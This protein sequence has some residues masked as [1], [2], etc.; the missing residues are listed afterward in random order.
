MEV[1]IKGRAVALAAPTSHVSRQKALLAVGQDTW[2]GLGACLGVCWA[3]K[4]P[5][6]ATLAGARWDGLTFGAAVRDELHALGAGEDDVA[7]AAAKALE[8]LVDSYP[9]EAAVA[10]HADFTAPPPAASTP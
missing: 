8:L 6:K 10:E 1:M 3:S 2:I 9:R 5:L 4:P 7:A